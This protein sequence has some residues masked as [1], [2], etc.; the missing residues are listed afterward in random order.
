MVDTTC[1]YLPTKALI[2]AVT[3]LTHDD[4]LFDLRL[5][6]ESFSSC[7]PGQFVQLWIPGVGEAPISVCSGKVD[8]QIQL[9]VRRVGRVT[10]ALFQLRKGDWVGLRGPYGHGFPVERLK[11][12]NL[13]LIAGGLGVAPLRSVWQYVLQHRKDYGRVILIYGARREVDLL[14]SEEL[15]SLQHRGDFQLEVAAEET[16]KHDHCELPIFR[17]L[18]TKPIHKA[19]IDS[20]F[21]AVICGPP[22][23]YKYVIAELKDKGVLP[24]HIWVSLER[25]MKCGIGKCGHCFIGGKFT[26]IKGPVFNL[27]ELEGFPEAVECAS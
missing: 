21:D 22:A 3:E 15:D 25:H 11:G 27:E 20:T 16:E 23:M 1:S 12:R 9:C 5:S 4:R 19:D 26:C 7:L 2:H 24:A 10:S 18:I 6:D 14:F 13:V 8:E 17:G